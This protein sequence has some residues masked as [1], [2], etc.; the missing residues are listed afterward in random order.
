MAKIPEPIASF[1]TTITNSITSTD[2]T[3][4]IDSVTDDDGNSMDAK[5]LGF[6]IDKGTSSE[7]FIIGTVD[8]ANTRL[9]SVTRG[10]SVTDGSSSVTALKSSHRKK[11]SIEISD[12]PYVVRIARALNGTDGIDPSYRPK[13]STD[14]DAT[15]DAEFVTRGEMNRTVGGS[16]TTSRVLVTATA[17]ETVAAGNLCYMDSTT[18]NEWM[19]CDADTAGTVDNRLLGIAQG[20]GTNGVEVSGGMLLM[21]LDSNQTGMTAGDVMYAGNTAGGISSSAGTTEVTVG[22]AHSAT[23]LFFSPR[24]N[25]QITEAQQDMLDTLT[26]A[27]VD[28]LVAI[29]SSAAELNTLDGYTGDV[30]DLNEMETF[31][32]ATDIT[33]AE[34]EALTD[35][36]VV[37]ETRH[38]H[39]N[40]LASS[41]ATV[42][43]A[44]TSE[45]TVATYTLPAGQL[46]TKHG[47][48]IKLHAVYTAADNGDNVTY[49]FKLGGTTVDDYAVTGSGAVTH[50]TIIECIIL[51]TSASAQKNVLSGHHYSN[52]NLSDVIDDTGTSAVDTS[53]AVAVAVTSQLVQDAGAGGTP[54]VT[55]KE[56]TIEYLYAA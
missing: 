29:T 9:T 32:G 30:N 26:A 34:A 27:A 35:G 18:N 45:Q 24:F 15:A 44:D 5:V 23:E 12:H 39:E 28:K 21:G 37:D 52:L 1:R 47:V 4:V 50:S 53:G 48:R 54:A 8:S 16:I 40:L 25:Q 51:N 17:G 13:L 55:I 22:I 43:T 3:I 49:R 10:V 7:E 6:V 41:I 19:L 11:A 36:S 2:T 33:G 14:T 31:F 56:C 42:L 38:S 20:A 46:G